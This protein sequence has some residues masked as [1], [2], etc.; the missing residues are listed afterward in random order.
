VLKTTKTTKTT[1]IWTRTLAAAT[2]LAA[3]ALVSAC[4]NSGEARAAAGAVDTAV[5]RTTTDVPAEGPA[6]QVT[7]TDA[8][9]VEKSTEYK[10]TPDN[11]AH[12]VA[13]ADSIAA[14]RGRDPAVSQFLSQNI[15]DA[16]AKTTDAGLQWLESNAPVNNAISSAGISTRDY[17]VASIAIA[18]AERFMNK[19]DAAPPTPTGKENAEFLRGHQ[20][21]LA[22]LR[23]LRENHP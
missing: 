22:H 6:V 19:P 2:A 14:L 7:R 12:F 11:F 5:A 16:G 15:D 8:K 9:S 1:R 17:Y 20:P 21:E 23:A 10:L 3:L 18:S 13:A 4:R